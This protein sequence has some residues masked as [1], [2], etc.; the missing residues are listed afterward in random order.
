MASPSPLPRGLGVEIDRAVRLADEGHVLVGGSPPRALRLTPSQLSALIRWASGSAPSGRSERVLARALIQG[1]LAHPRPAPPVPWRSTDDV[2]VA[3]VGQAGARGL[4]RTLDR[5][6][7]LHPAVRPLVVGATG[8]VARVARARGARVV[9][10]PAGGPQARAEALRVCSAEF[11][12]L[13]ESGSWP[14]PGWLDAALGHF[15]DPGVAAVVPRVLTERP[16]AAGHWRRTVAAVAASRAGADRGADPSPVLPWG[17]GPGRPGAGNEHTAADP[18]RPLPALVLRRCALDGRPVAAPAPE[19]AEYGSGWSEADGDAIGGAVLAPE[20]GAGAELDLVWRLAE[21]GWA[22]RYEPRA[23]LWSLPV[24]DL[25]GY[26]RACF[27]TGA[28]VAPL[29]R[30][31]GRRAAGP[32]L[33]PEG[34]VGLALAASG[35]PG[36]GAAVAALTG[37]AAVREEPGGAL[38]PWPETARSVVGDVAHTARLGSRALREAWWPVAASAV[39]ACALRRDRGARRIALV[40]G[41]ALVLPHL[42]AWRADRGAVLVGPLTWTALSMAG[43]AARSAG[44]WWGALRSGSVAPLV[45]RL[46]TRARR[47]TLAVRARDEGADAASHVRTV[48]LLL[49]KGG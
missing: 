14:G 34:A 44:T 8:P 13:L 36:S 33:Y 9:P 29:A 26:L 47:G 7:E 46:R 3:V 31:H 16:R 6:A 42:S 11:V 39:L 40:G 2:D 30:R 22:V 37:V 5:L 10:G 4:A 18:L 21:R 25:G 1:G 27:G 49:V 32:E 17:Q 28:L 19:A 48:S 20:L 43:D 24:T 23:R 12:V 45:P 38:P 41:A 35:R 15:A